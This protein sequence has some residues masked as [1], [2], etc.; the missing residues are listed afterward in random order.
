MS[1]LTKSKTKISYKD[2][3]AGYSDSAQ[4]AKSVAERNFKD[5]CMEEFEGRTHL[6]VINE[7]SAIQKT[8]PGA[9]Y[10]VI[11]KWI[12]WNKDL[13]PASLRAYMN[14]VKTLLRFYGVKLTKED[15]K[16]N[17]SMPR[18]HEEDLH[19]CSLDEV[20]KNS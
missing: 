5:F 2:R 15:L 4:K 6:E 12:N 9:V 16:D 20:K 7:M 17:V 3:L 13:N 19:P 11:Q 10:E 8:D 14:N 18:I 1:F